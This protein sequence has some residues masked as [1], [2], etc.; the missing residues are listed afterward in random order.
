MDTFQGTQK[1]FNDAHSR[2]MNRETPFQT[3]VRLLESVPDTTGH[4]QPIL[5]STNLANKDYPTPTSMMSNTGGVAVPLFVPPNTQN[6][7]FV[8]LVD[9]NQVA[10]HIAGLDSIVPVIPQSYVN[11][12]GMLSDP[13]QILHHLWTVT[14]ATFGYVIWNYQDFAHQFQSWD[15]SIN[16][17]LHH[18]GL[19]WRTMV[20]I[21]LTLGILELGPFIDGLSRIFMEIGELIV[22][23]FRL[24]ETT[25]SEMWYFLN[26]LWEDLMMPVKWMMSS[27]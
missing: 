26:I 13:R 11:Q 24:V 19:L 18:M 2:A 23:V 5:M 12:W 25:A 8:P 27:K 22:F 17:L 3:E 10:S 15:G 4:R 9:Q 16:G 21:L 14:N 20:T 6:A 1:W 7:Q